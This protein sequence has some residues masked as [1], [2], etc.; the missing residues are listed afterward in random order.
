MDTTTPSSAARIGEPPPAPMSVPVWQERYP[1]T[2]WMRGPTLPET[3]APGAGQ[4]R[5]PGPMLTGTPD[6]P[7]AHEGDPGQQLVGVRDGGGRPAALLAQRG[8]DDAVGLAGAVVPGGHQPVELAPQQGQLLVGGE[9]ADAV[10]EAGKLG[11]D[12]AGR[13]AVPEGVGLG[14]GGDQPGTDEVGEPEDEVVDA[15]VHPGD[16]LGEAPGLRLRVGGCLGADGAGLAAQ[17]GAVLVVQLLGLVDLALVEQRRRHHRD[18][19]ASTPSARLH[20]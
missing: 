7:L 18:A 6:C 20:P 11:V 4:A 10:G 8:V 5:P 13:G 2:G 12:E 15:G 16:P 14:A 1:Y 17:H 9:L 3:G 19:A